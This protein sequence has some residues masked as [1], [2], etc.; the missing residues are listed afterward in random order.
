MGIKD[1]ATVAIRLIICERANR[2][3]KVVTERCI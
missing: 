1:A 2:Q 3:N